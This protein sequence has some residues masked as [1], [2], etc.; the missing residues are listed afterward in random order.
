MGMTIKNMKSLQ[1]KLNDLSNGEMDQTVEKGVMRGGKLIQG[2]AKLL[3]PVALGELRSS[4]R[5]KKLKGFGNKIGCIIFTNND[6]AAPVEFGT[7]PV[8]QANHEGISPNVTPV[9]VQHG[10]DI[11]ADKVSSADAEKYHWP[12]RTYS[13]KKYYM[14]SGQRAQPFMY[15]A[16]KTAEKELS[17]VVG[18]EI[19]SAL[20]KK[21]VK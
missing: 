20:V 11:P 8:G 14:T 1:R 15:P 18:N 10:W 4:I 2:K 7:G 21:C 6:H 13:G 16:A 12:T 19:A 17:T 9:Y 3:C 5:T